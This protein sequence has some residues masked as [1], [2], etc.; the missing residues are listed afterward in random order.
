MRIVFIIDHFY[1]DRA[2]TENQL[3]KMIRGLS[4]RFEIELIC[5]R[6]SEWLQTRAPALPCGVRIFQIDKFK[7]AYTYRNLYRL[8]RHLRATRPNVVHTFFPVANIVGVLCARFARVP[9]IVSSRRDYGEW[10]RRHYLAMTRCA[11]RFVHGIVTNSHRVKQLTE[12]IEKVDGRLIEV[13]YNG[14]DVSGFASLPR[15]EALKRELGIPPANKVIGIVANFR[16]MKRHETLIHAAKIVLAARSDIDFLLV[17]ADDGIVGMRGR[18]EALAE[19]L[20]VRARLHFVGS[21]KDVARYLSIMDVGVNC[22]EG[23]GL[24]NAIMEYMAAGVPCIVSDSGGNPDLVTDGVTGQTFPLGDHETLAHRLLS[25]L[26]DHAT[27]Q[28][29]AKSARQKLYDEMNMDIM[30]ERFDAFYRSLVGA[31][32]SAGRER[33]TG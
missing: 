13:I 8:V 28:C 4:G 1:S 22:S 31:T 33:V 16:P 10:M 12:R 3:V 14:I 5:F 6:D 11:N 17:G 26:D 19:E 25:T 30:I 32:G 15:D 23:E 24:S 21:C 20:G 18:T 7:R 2:G 9:R 27:R 29:F